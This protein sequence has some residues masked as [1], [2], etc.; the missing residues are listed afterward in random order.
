MCKK[1]SHSTIRSN[2]LIIVM[3][4]V[5]AVITISYAILYTLSFIGIEDLPF[6]VNAIEMHLLAVAFLVLTYGKW[7]KQL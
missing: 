2:F 5:L 3:R 4:S 6:E 7:N 1:K